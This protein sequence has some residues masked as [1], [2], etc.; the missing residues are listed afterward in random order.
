M[1]LPE[2]RS[3]P[4]NILAAANILVY[5]GS[6]IAGGNLLQTDPEIL[7]ALGRVNRLVA[8]GW[9]WQLFTSMFI[10]INLIH[11]LG[12]M[13]FLAIFGLGT[14]ALYSGRQYYAIYFSSGLLGSILSIFTGL[15][16]VSAGA[17]GSIF[18]LFGAVM[19]YSGSVNR[20]SMLVTLTY[21]IY[22]LLLNIGANVNIYAHAGGLLAGLALGYRYTEHQKD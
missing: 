20:Q 19:I 11:L 3:T 8:E 18:G 17:S 1:N 12:N 22:F 13:I 10:H 14:E 5:A 2:V 7:M 15:E 9:I 16:A 6:S 21:S 4:T